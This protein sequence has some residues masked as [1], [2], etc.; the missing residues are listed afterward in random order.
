MPHGTPDL[1]QQFTE[2]V[3]EPRILNSHPAI[4]RSTQ[5]FRLEVATR[6]FAGTLSLNTRPVEH[7]VSLESGAQQRITDNSC[8]S[9]IER[10]SAN[11][12]CRI[13]F[14]ADN[15]NRFI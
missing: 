13:K 7:P 8:Y 1:C 11:A 9:S 6:A 5:S 10:I 4:Y 15:Y 3:A 14:S 2:S 12:V